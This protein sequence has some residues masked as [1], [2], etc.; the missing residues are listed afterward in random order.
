MSTGTN[1]PA[2]GGATSTGTPRRP[3]GRNH[4]RHQAR[5]NTSNTNTFKGTLTDMNGHVFQCYGEATEKNQFDEELTTGSHQS[6][7][8]RNT[9]QQH[10]HNPNYHSPRNQRNSPK[11][12]T[13]LS[14][15]V[16]HVQKCQKRRYHL[17]PNTQKNAQKQNKSPC[18]SL[19]KLLENNGSVDIMQRCS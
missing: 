19:H 5:T 8:N 4:I 16:P 18:R 9:L 3:S 2:A 1:T 11:E 10:W 12:S 15:L 13:T 7:T 6:R 14:T 17:E